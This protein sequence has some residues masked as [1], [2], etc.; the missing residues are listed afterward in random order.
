M[1]AEDLVAA[2]CLGAYIMEVHPPHK[3]GALLDQLG[4]KEEKWRTAFR[5]G[6]GVDW[7]TVERKLHQW[8][9]DGR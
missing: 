6:L 1:T 3:V 9:S 4:N 7:R 8:I 5:K 2:Y